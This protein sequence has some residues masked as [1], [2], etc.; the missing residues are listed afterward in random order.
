M[1]ESHLATWASDQDLRKSAKGA[2]GGGSR[3][4]PL[5]RYELVDEGA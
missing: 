5:M 4:V 3:M 1:S 2:P